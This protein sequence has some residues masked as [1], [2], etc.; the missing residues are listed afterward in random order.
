M[1]YILTP[2]KTEKGLKN[3]K[4]SLENN[5]GVLSKRSAVLAFTT[6]EVLYPKIKHLVQLFAEDNPIET[7][8][9]FEKS[10]NFE[11]VKKYLELSNPNDICVLLDEK[12]IMPRGAL[13]KM[14][15]DYS[16][17]SG[18]GLITGQPYKAKLNYGLND[19]YN[20]KKRSEVSSEGLVKIE[21]CPSFFIM[22]RMEL[23]LN[24]N[25]KTRKNYSYELT[26]LGYAN[27]L[28]NDVKFVYGA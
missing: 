13:K 8:V 14:L 28:D 19:I 20:P 1:L 23:F 24:F 10:L 9:S 16:L 17:K 27:Y 7:L 18:I 3:L 22:T 26:K 21:V 5:F 11:N 12:S 15:E 4:I 6:D 25:F 2:V